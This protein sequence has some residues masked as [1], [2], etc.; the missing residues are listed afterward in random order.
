MKTMQKNKF[1]RFALI[2]AS[3]ACALLFFT[4]FSLGSKTARA[5]APQA[6]TTAYVGDV[7]EAAD[8]DISYNGGTIK[9]E[10]LTVVYPSG[11]VYGG[12]SFVMNQAGNYQVTYY[13]NADGKRVEETKNYIAIRMPQNLVVGEDGMLIEHG[14]YYVGESPYEL[15]NDTYGALVTFKAG[16]SITFDTTIKTSD[17][18]ASQNIIDM[19]VM[20]SIFRETDFEKLSV[21]VTDCSDENNYVDIVIMSSNTVDGNG[22][23]SYVQAGAKG[24]QVGGYE[25]E[26]FHMNSATYGTEVEHSFRGLARVGENREKHTVSENSLTIAID[27]E[28]RQVYCG[29]ISNT[30]V[31]MHMVNDLDDPAHYK[32]NPWGGFLGEEVSVKVTA[33]RFAKAEGKLLIKQFGGYDLSQAVEDTQ[34]PELKVAYDE[35]SELPLAKVGEE[36]PI[37]P[38]E[39]KDML[40]KNVNANVY[41][42]YL[43]NNGTKINVAHNGESFLAKY[44]GKYQVVYCAKDYS[45]NVSEKTLEIL[46]Q[47]ELPEISVDIETPLVEMDAYETV[48]IPQAWEMDAIGGSGYLTI[49]R[50]VYDPNDNVLDVEDELQL[51]LVGDYRVVYTV[52][53]YL[54]NEKSEAMVIRSNEIDKPYFVEEPNFDPTFIKGFKYELPTVYV[55]E[56]ANG[57]MQEVA[58]KISVNG[59]LNTS[60][61]FT[62]TGESVTITYTAEGVSGTTVVEKTIPVVDTEYGKYKSLY[63]YTESNMDIVDE[64]SYLEFL[65]NE[66]CQTQ[67]INPLAT[68]GFAMTMTYEEAT[69]LFGTMKVTLVDAHNVKN[70]VTIEFIYDRYINMWAIKMN[71]SDEMIEYASS[72]NTLL[73]AL[74]NGNQIMDESGVGIATIKSYDNGKA[75]AGFSDSVYLH[76]SFD[77]VEGASSIRLTQIGNQSMGYNKSS[78]DKA[79]DEIK[80]VIILDEPVMMRQKLGS[81]AQ[82]PTAKAYDVLG[83]VQE[84]TVKLEM[85]TDDGWALLVS[86]DA[87]NKLNY[88]FEKA[89]NYRITYF[90]KDT[91]RNSMTLPYALMVADET[92]PELSVKDSIKSSYSV[93][94]KISVP[95]YKVSD[96]DG[97]YTVQVT[98]I[99]PNNEMRLLQYNENGEIT[100][101]LL[102]A[103]E[104]SLYENAFISD[105]DTFV[106]LYKGKYVLRIL[107]YDEYYNYVAEEIEFI[108]K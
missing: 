100:F 78:L 93:G 54:G 74:L 21:R 57:Q 30:S 63:F 53:D 84:F 50:V 85:M 40:D 90:A 87:T 22:Q 68:E 80:P 72:R 33:E 77:G 92:A 8:Y 88:T 24:Q 3:F 64:K 81:V 52:T 16:Q 37:F 19:I 48:K 11:G 51:T 15:K 67:F 2:L 47:E 96:N 4:T 82:I 55:V 13:A 71:D 103:K 10:G 27:N 26:R 28:T 36:F 101:T 14:K 5:D 44:A 94:A 29:P 97:Y 18:T 20:P 75:F 91:N 69:A 9:A 76:I 59:E 99:L 98:L 105:E 83:Q 45:G 1:L 62:A 34:A 79:E 6:V 31:A 61:K 56:S 65:F 106:A 32:G 104:G 89:G 58:C 86:G 42:Y 49:D 95:S 73:F 7:I 12:D 35:N 46:A 25:N 107:A 17:L 108:V 41:V 66:A 60:G 23:V 102:S 70:A 39:A 43:A 38:F